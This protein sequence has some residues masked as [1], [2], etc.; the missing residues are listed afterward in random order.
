MNRIRA[1]LVRLGGL[2]RRDRDEQEMNAE[3]ESHLQLH[4]DDN[5]RAGMSPTE[6]RRD[7]VL[8]LGGIESVKEAM[9]DRQ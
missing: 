8:K 9:R 5:V 7:A 6:A 3:I 4:I 1:F 2:L